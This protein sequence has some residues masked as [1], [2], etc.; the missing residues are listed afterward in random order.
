MR[1]N[2]LSL[3]NVTENIAFSMTSPTGAEMGLYKIQDNKL[4]HFYL[5]INA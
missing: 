5:S 4:Y 3:F 2:L 1:V